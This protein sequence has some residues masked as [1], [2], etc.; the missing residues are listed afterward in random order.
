MVKIIRRTEELREKGGGIL[1]GNK[2]KLKIRGRA[3][4]VLPRP[5]L[6]KVKTSMKN[7]S[8]RRKT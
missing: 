1:H 6:K 2:T 3:E 4:G 5:I 8:M 7:P